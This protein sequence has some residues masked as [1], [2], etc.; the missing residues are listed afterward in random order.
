MTGRLESLRERARLGLNEAA[1]ELRGIVADEIV[2]LEVRRDEIKEAVEQP[3][4]QDWQAGR[5]IDLGPEATRLHRYE[6]AADRLFRSAWTKLERIRKE[7]G[8]PLIYRTARPAEPGPRPNPER[9]RV[10]RH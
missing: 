5:E 6:A 2:R 8:E 7:Q 9:D 4:L 3:M 1:E 10:M